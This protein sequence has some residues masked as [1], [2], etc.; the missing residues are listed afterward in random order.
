MRSRSTSVNVPL[1]KMRRNHRFRESSSLNLWEKR[2]G[3]IPSLLGSLTGC[4]LLGSLTGCS[5][6][7]SLTGCVQV[8]LISDRE[9]LFAVISIYGYCSTNTNTMLG[10]DYVTMTTP[11]EIL[12]HSLLLGRRL[13]SFSDDHSPSSDKS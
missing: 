8:Q 1:R 4:S 6:L 2:S 7:G 12:R 3:E 11:A 5:L 13:L 9:K 10:R